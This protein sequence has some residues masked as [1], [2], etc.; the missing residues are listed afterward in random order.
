MGC[1]MDE[2]LRLHVN[3]LRS[4]T[5]SNV[6]VVGCYLPRIPRIPRS[7]LRALVPGAGQTRTVGCYTSLYGL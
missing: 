2:Q 6:E 1:R 7:I 4:R 3:M 5:G